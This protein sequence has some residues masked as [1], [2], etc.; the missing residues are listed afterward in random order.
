[1]SLPKKE[2]Q[3]FDLKAENRKLRQALLT[4]KSSIEE[5]SKAAEQE[6]KR[7]VRK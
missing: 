4:V 5:Q 1:M 2:K 3:I 6:S 7:K